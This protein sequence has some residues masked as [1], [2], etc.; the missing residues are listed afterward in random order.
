MSKDKEVN[1]EIDSN[2]AR[3]VANDP[4]IKKSR[5]GLRMRALNRK[6]AEDFV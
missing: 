1:V 5:C 6:Y 4:N 2:D 3:K